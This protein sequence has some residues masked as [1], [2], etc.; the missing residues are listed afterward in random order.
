[1][2]WQDIVRVAST[3]E[4]SVDNHEMVAEAKPTGSTGS[5]PP[6]TPEQQRKRAAKQAVTQ[7]QVRSEQNRHN[8]RMRELR[9]KAAKP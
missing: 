9:L 7:Q 1:M 8:D 3:D 2:R 6:L 4:N 5:I